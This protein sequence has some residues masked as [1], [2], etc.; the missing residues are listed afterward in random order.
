[1][2]RASREETPD[3]ATPQCRTWPAVVSCWGLHRPLRGSASRVLYR[4]SGWSRMGHAA[5]AKGERGTGRSTN[6]QYRNK[7]GGTR[8]NQL[9]V[10]ALDLASPLG[11]GTGLGA[12]NAPHATAGQ[13]GLGGLPK[14]ESAVGLA[15]WRNRPANYRWRID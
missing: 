11:G 8:T 13:L 12:R 1:M 15:R 6:T 5:P 4:H 9:D 3:G 10:I 14:T 2:G 7:N